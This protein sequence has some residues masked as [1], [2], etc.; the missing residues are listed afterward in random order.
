ML[1]AAG[2]DWLGFPLRLAVH[3]EDLAEDEAA[4]IIRMLPPEHP[5]V[6][7]TYLDTAAAIARLCR[8][9]GARHA[10]VH[11]EMPPSGLLLLR[12]LSPKLF[13][14][15]GLIVRDDDE[16]ELLGTM[17]EYERCVDAFITDTYDP[18]TGACGA[19]GIG[20]PGP[21]TGIGMATVAWSWVH[22]S[23]RTGS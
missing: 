14:I 13:I 18:A 17:H 23:W 12:E 5:G 19:T 1:I 20:M 8:K 22:H 6:L 15:K 4:E 2:V 16:D 11:G 10:Q 7:I 21:E 3:R 9:L